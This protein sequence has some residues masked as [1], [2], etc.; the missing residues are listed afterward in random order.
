MTFHRVATQHT[1]DLHD[2]FKHSQQNNYIEI[3]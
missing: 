2:I 3:L 1:I